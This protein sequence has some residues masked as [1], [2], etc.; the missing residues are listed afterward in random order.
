[1][2]NQ[3]Q[4]PEPS[5]LGS[6]DEI[7]QILGRANPNP[8]RIGCPSRDVLIALARRARRIGDPAYE[9]LVKCSPCY[10][11]FRGL[12]TSLTTGYAGGAGVRWA[13]VAAI[14]VLLVGGA[15]YLF[16]RPQNGGRSV[17]VPGQ[18]VTDLQAELDLRNY[19]V[20][21]SEQVPTPPPP[22]SLQ[23]GRLNATILLPVGS[24]PGA[25]E[26]QVLDAELR[27]QAA[28]SGQAD[29][30]NY[31]TTLR[32]TIDLQSLP[33]GMYQLALRR[34]GDEWRMFP[35]SVK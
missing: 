2:A 28:A 25:Y 33:P 12:Q 27:S 11:E 26:V 16:S 13:A 10:R 19:S 20:T 5:D 15:W 3:T 35:A 7:D 22:L 18:A 14:L 30:K 23:R 9:H 6:K 8:E 32:A 24:E 17:A 29:I 1:M 21:R 4:Q 31:V 34:Q